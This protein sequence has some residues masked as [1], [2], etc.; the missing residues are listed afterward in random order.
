MRVKL[1]AAQ[2]RQRTAAAVL[3]LSAVSVQQ[4]SDSGCV[5][6]GVFCSCADRC[7]SLVCMLHRAPQAVGEH[8]FH[9]ICDSCFGG[10][11]L[12]LCIPPG[13]PWNMVICMMVFCAFSGS[14]PPSPTKASKGRYGEIKLSMLVS[15]PGAEPSPKSPNC[16]HLLVVCACVCVYVYVYVTYVHMCVL[17]HVWMCMCVFLCECLCV[18]IYTYMCVCVQLHVCNVHVVRAC[19]SMGIQF[20]EAQLEGS[21]AECAQL[22][23]KVLR[24]RERHQ[25]EKRERQAYKERVTQ[26]EADR[27]FFFEC[28][29]CRPLAPWILSY[30]MDLQWYGGHHSGMP[31]GTRLCC[32]RRR[33]L[34]LASS[35]ADCRM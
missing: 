26:A 2:P 8:L 23:E 11:V 34:A 28:A 18:H 31:P 5:V 29:V 21:R 1:Q 19:V 6:L 7:G 27:F 9:S 17:M 30:E 32:L 13:L 3:S 35:F 15:S 25:Q 20:L 12:S 24:K 14:A 22:R 10:P 33:L 4:R 16:G